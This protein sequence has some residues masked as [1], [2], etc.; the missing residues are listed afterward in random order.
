MFILENYNWPGN[1]RELKNASC[2][3]VSL[4]EGNQITPLD[5]P[6]EMLEASDLGRL[7]MGRFRETQRQVLTQF[8]RSYLEQLLARSEG[9]MS[10]AARE[11]G[12]KRSTLYRLFHKHGLHPS[13]F[14]K[15]NP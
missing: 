5:L 1:V 11:A 9:N 10:R 7:A 4:T 2:R 6:P 12:M 3:A 13:A 8:E 15:E 14:R